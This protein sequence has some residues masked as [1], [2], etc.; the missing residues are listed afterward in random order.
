MV[1]RPQKY[2][3]KTSL[4]HFSLPVSFINHL[5][6]L[7]KDNNLSKTELIIN[8]FNVTDEDLL[9]KF[10]KDYN[11]LKEAYSNLSKEFK[12]ISDKLQASTITLLY[13]QVE[14]DPNLNDFFK[15]FKEKYKG[16]FEN[17]NLDDKD[18]Y[19]MFEEWLLQNK[20]KLIKNKTIIKVAIRNFLKEIYGSQYK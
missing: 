14:L 18:I 6:Q 12:L 2:G 3:E 9:I 17:I 16:R 15:Y 19:N 20:N 7:S 13:K 11:N 10:T 1:G 4:Q 8:T 5:E